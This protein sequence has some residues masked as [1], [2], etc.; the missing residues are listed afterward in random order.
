MGK[1]GAGSLEK[2]FYQLYL[3]PKHTFPIKYYFICGT[4]NSLKDKFTQQ[5]Q[6]S[7]ISNTALA[8]SEIH[9]CINHQDVSELMNLGSLM[10]SK[11][12]GATVA[13]CQAM[14]L[15]LLM[16]FSH[17]LWEPANERQIIKAV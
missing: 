9:G 6:S 14:G 11:P 1:N 16:L 13:E 15:P 7:D 2:I 10:I 5:L 8:K 17:S 12:G 4:N 3:G